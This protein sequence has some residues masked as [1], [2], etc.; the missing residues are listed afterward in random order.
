MPFL[1]PRH[2]VIAVSYDVVVGVSPSL[3][4][5]N[6]RFLVRFVIIVGGRPAV[7]DGGLRVVGGSVGELDR[8]RDLV[9]NGDE[10]G[11]FGP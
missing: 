2:R 11:E 8:A 3:D 4:Q 7:D 6:Q 1:Q 9:A 10:D 5:L